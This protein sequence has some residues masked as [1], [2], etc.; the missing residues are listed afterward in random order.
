MNPRKNDT[1]SLGQVYQTDFLNRNWC[2]LGYYYGQT[3]NGFHAF[4]HYSDTLKKYLTLKSGLN[5]LMINLKWNA[6]SMWIAVCYSSWHDNCRYSGLCY[7]T[8]VKI[9]LSRMMF[10]RITKTL[11]DARVLF[12]YN[13]IQVHSFEGV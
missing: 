7:I 3:R 4:R 6:S 2:Y 9:D 1:T 11:L 12:L 13:I 5:N 10:H 8:K